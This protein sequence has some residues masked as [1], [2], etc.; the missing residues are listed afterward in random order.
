[1]FVY[2]MMA[3]AVG[4]AAVVLVLVSCSRSA[5]VRA[6]RSC[7][8]VAR[9]EVNDV[10]TQPRR[11]RVTDRKRCNRPHLATL[12]QA[13]KLS[14]LFRKLNTDRLAVCSGST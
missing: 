7:P 14:Q 13:M 4:V 5:R 12:V 1:M 10:R 11:T 2:N 3:I 9:D 8:G 6:L